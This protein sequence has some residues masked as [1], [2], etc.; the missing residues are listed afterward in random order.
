MALVYPPGYT[1]AVTNPLDD[2]P[3]ARALPDPAE[4]A[5]VLGAIL[6]GLQEADVEVSALRRDAVLELRARPM[7]L[8][9]I[10]A[11]LKMSRGRVQ[12]ILGRA[13]HDR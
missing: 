5:R 9:E 2:L 8:G 3:R 4:R 6:G 11:E 13:D 10:A 1:I 7:S 12:R